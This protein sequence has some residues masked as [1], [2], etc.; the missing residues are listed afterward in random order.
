MNARRGGDTAVEY[1]IRS[2]ISG[3]LAEG[4]IGASTKASL[5]WSAESR[6]SGK[7]YGAELRKSYH[8]IDRVLIVVDFAIEESTHIVGISVK[9]E[10]ASRFV[11][12]FA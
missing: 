3:G 6:I 7:R 2:R 11:Q 5:T 1:R 9:Q 12:H 8:A 4:V 10:A